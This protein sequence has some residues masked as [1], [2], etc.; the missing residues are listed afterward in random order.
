MKLIIKLIANSILFLIIFSSCSSSVKTAQTSPVETIKTEKSS[1]L[2]FVLLDSLSSRSA[3]ITDTID[4]FF[5][6]VTQVDVELQLKRIYV[7]GNHEAIGK[8]YAYYL[9]R[10]VM[11]FSEKDSTFLMPILKEVQNMCEEMDPNFFTQPV[12]L[13]KVTGNMYGNSVYY[14]RQHCIIIPANELET[15]KA[16]KVKEILIHEM[17]HIYSRYH[18]DF[19]KK[20]YDLIGFEEFNHEIS[21]PAPL[22]KLY[23]INPDGVNFNYYIQI[24]DPFTKNKVKAVPVIY[25]NAEHYTGF[26]P[27]FFEYLEFNLYPIVESETIP[28]KYELKCNKDGGS[29][30]TLQLVTDFYTQIKDNTNYI[31]HPDEI[32]ADNFTFLVN[33]LKKGKT[34]NGVKDFSKDGIELMKKLEMLFPTKK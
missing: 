11:N 33:Y 18:P 24:T 32:M 8:E 30:I 19:R 22:D 21:I 15:A 7:K 4:K 28:N 5:D 3:I 2:K 14:T 16:E 34:N 13:I 1:K 17:F 20:A 6:K 29:P 23:L 25:S 27:S 12:K 10:D 31:I 26:K 9:K